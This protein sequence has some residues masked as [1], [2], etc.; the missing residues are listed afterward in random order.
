MTVRRD[1]LPDPRKM[2]RADLPDACV[3]TGGQALGAKQISGTCDR[4]IQILLDVQLQIPPDPKGT[5]T[6]VLLENPQ[7]GQGTTGRR[8]SRE[9]RA[10]KTFRFP[11]Q[12]LPIQ[13]G[14]RGTRNEFLRPVSYTRIW[15]PPRV[16]TH[17]SPKN[18]PILL[19]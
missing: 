15:V 16:L 5:P 10:R 7:D 11:L 6:L 14:R 2:P 3:T 9:R 19:Q 18:R 1:I 4:W 13:A 8:P 12:C 17:D